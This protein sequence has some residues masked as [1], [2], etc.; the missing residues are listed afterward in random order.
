MD[1]RR[2]WMR[3]CLEEALERH[4]IEPEDVLRHADPSVLATDL[5]PQLVASLLAKGL[6]EGHFDASLLVGHLGAEELATHVPLSVLWNCLDEAATTM[7]AEHPLTH[8]EAG[9][10]PINTSVEPD[11]QPEIELIAE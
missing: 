2:A 1:K 4:V 6:Q 8:R 3:V 9:L 5:P 10:V 11:E 7:I